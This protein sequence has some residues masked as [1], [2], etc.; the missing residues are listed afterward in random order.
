MNDSIWFEIFSRASPNKP[1]SLDDLM[2][3]DQSPQPLGKV[4]FPQM[5]FAPAVNLWPREQGGPVYIGVRILEP[6]ETPYTVARLLAAAALERDVCPIILSRVD[7]CGL[8]RFGFRV[9]RIP[10]DPGAA[11]S[12]EEE[13]G[14]YWDLAIIINGHE[15]GMLR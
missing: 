7:Y 8:E 4:V 5:R 6:P 10:E 11:Q 1:V 2:N 3:D 12:A 15:I 13:I 14:K 9:E